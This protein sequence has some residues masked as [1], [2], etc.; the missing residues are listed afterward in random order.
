M[1]EVLESFENYTEKLV[2]FNQQPSEDAATDFLVASDDI[3]GLVV[4]PNHPRKVYEGFQEFAGDCDGI[5]EVWRNGEAG[6][7]EDPTDSL[8]RQSRAALMSTG[9]RAP[10]SGKLTAG[11]LPEF[12]D[13]IRD[14][15]DA[16]GDNSR[17][18]TAFAFRRIRQD[19]FSEVT[20]LHTGW[21]SHPLPRPQAIELG[22]AAMDV[23]GYPVGYAGRL[24][25]AVSAIANPNPRNRNNN[26]LDQ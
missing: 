4:F 18:F 24:A 16:L 19:L 21:N 17:K 1:A 20:T 26:P 7:Y 6:M 23:V 15:V 22:K 14:G 10:F 11:D 2:G 13:I 12:Y 9:Y 5:V 8:R 3:A 25:L